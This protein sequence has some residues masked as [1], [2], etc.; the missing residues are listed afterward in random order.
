MIRKAMVKG[1]DRFW[2]LRDWSRRD[3][4]KAKAMTFVMLNPSTADDQVD[5]PTIRKCIGFAERAG[6]QR[7]YVVNLFS[8]RATDPRELRHGVGHWM[9]NMLSVRRLLD[10]E[11]VVFAW[12]TSLL[13]APVPAR[14]YALG[15]LAEATAELA[16]EPMCLGV[17]KDG[18]PRHPLMLPYTTPLSPWTGYDVPQWAFLR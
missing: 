13:H 5:D 9:T 14:E 16:V 3:D 18:H 1:D 7:I 15:W 6:Y 2:L 12:G 4:L 8:V 17:S 10:S 11:C